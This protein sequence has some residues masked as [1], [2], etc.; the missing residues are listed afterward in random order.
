[1]AS[2]LAFIVFLGAAVYGAAVPALHPT[3]VFGN[4]P[5]PTKDSHQLAPRQLSGPSIRSFRLAAQYAA[6]AYCPL[7]KHGEGQLVY[8]A[9]GNCPIVEDAGARLFFAPDLPRVSD[10]ALIAID[11]KNERV[12]LAIRGSISRPIRIHEPGDY[13]LTIS[14]DL[15]VGCAFAWGLEDTWLPMENAVLESIKRALHEHETFRLVVTGHSMGGGFA[16]VAAARIRRANNG[17]FA[18]ITDLYTFGAPFF[19]NNKAVEWINDIGGPNF[20]IVN[21]QDF[22]RFHS[23]VT[24]VYAIERNFDNPTPADIDVF[25]EGDMLPTSTWWSREANGHYF[26]NIA[27]CK[28]S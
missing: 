12:V 26:G 5:V 3:T 7:D 8:C 23:N 13:Y 19:G 16:S 20:F 10:D 1:M 9:A 2:M 22:N 28:A 6:A 17:E 14:S 25:A 27:G 21:A 4:A 15:C 24:P 11:D 18:D